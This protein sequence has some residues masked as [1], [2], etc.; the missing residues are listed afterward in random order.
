MAS[1]L[2]RFGAFI[3][4]FNMEYRPVWMYGAGFDEYSFK[5]DPGFGLPRSIGRRFS[6]V[7]HS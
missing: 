3:Q 2:I 1:Y 6:H 4:P 5:L 7:E